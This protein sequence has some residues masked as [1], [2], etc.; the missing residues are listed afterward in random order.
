L[1]VAGKDATSEFEDVGHSEEAK[2]MM[3][4]YFI[5]TL[6][7]ADGN[8]SPVQEKKKPK[9]VNNNKLPPPEESSGWSKLIIPI[10]VIAL[11]ALVVNFVMGKV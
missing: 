9:V 2:T 3:K 7:D 8:T 10:G 4:N 6:A 1:D 5:G 11:V